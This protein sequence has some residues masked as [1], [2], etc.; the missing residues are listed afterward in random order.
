MWPK[1]KNF[2]S[3]SVLPLQTTSC[4]AWRRLQAQITIKTMSLNSCEEVIC[5]LQKIQL[6]NPVICSRQDYIYKLIS[7]LFIYKISRGQCSIP[8]KFTDNHKLAPWHTL[9]CIPVSGTVYAFQTETCTHTWTGLPIS[10]GCD[11]LKLGFFLWDFILNWRRRKGFLTFN[12]KKEK[13]RERERYT[14]FRNQ[15]L[16]K[17]H[18]ESLVKWDQHNIVPILWELIIFDHQ[19]PPILIP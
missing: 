13:E 6:L 8:E 10:I 19:N 12:G 3:V 2:Q 7:V 5:G 18:N 14:H 4:P 11:R 1:K 16:I 17:H 9:K 15:R